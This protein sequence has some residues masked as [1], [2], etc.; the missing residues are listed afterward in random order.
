MA[1]VRWWARVYTCVLPPETAARRTA[2]I[3]SDLWECQHDAN[4]CSQ[5]QSPMHL[6]IRLIFGIADDV[7]WAAE[8]AFPRHSIGLGLRRAVVMAIAML[9]LITG[10]GVIPLSSRNNDRERTQISAHKRD[11]P[12]S[13]ERSSQDCLETSGVVQGVVSGPPTNSIS[14]R[15][16]CQ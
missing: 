11:L 2:E 7:L 4:G 12:A 8:H 9:L 3:E 6:F 15:V 1:S 16:M 5:A 14:M 13:R 10:V